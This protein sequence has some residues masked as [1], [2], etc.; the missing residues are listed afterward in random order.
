MVYKVIIAIIVG[1]IIVTY[2]M[3][4]SSEEASVKGS[5]QPLI[6]TSSGLQ[7]EE[8]LVGSGAS[9][10][11]GQK[12]VVHYTGTLPNGQKFDS[13]RDRGQPFKFTL[14]VGQ[15]IKGWDEGLSTMKVGGKRNLVIPANLGYGP[16]AV[17]NVIPA[18]ATLHFEVELLGI[19]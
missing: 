19:E 7:Y 4:Q 2:K 11:T 9:P 8:V 18:N 5:G 6:T 16:R 3:N 15:V 17:G 10:Q 1:V 14:G 12:V 13:S